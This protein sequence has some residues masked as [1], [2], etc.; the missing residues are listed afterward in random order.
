[1][2]NMG[3]RI[4]DL[5]TNDS[6]PS[7]TELKILETYFVE[8]TPAIRGGGNRNIHIVKTM[9]VIAVFLALS[10]PKVDEVLSKFVNNNLYKT[11]IK[12]A[13]IG[14]VLL[15]IFPTFVLVDK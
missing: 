13:L 11:L 10:Q 1:M 9:I 3:D 5:Q 7:N 6:R 8:P 2:V 15:L 4:D 12:G 14:L